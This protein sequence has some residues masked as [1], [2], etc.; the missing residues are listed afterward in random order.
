MW[1]LSFE[2]DSTLSRMIPGKIILDMEHEG[3]MWNIMPNNSATLNL[4]I[5]QDLAMEIAE[6]MGITLED[7]KEN[8]PGGHI[9]ELLR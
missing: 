6:K 5:L 7:F 1:L 3:D 9:G 2:K 8:H 4:I